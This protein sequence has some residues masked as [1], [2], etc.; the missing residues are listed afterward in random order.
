MNPPSRPLREYQSSGRG[1]L[2]GS[3]MFVARVTA[4]I[5]GLPTVR[6][7]VGEERIPKIHVT[8][9]PDMRGWS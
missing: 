9:G 5:R 8:Y 2:Q 7:A 6:V 3:V 1:G 4:I